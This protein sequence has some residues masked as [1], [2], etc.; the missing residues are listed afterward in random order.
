M[1]DALTA[2][3]LA[4]KARQNAMIVAKPFILANYANNYIPQ[5]QKISSYF[6]V[7]F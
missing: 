4:E 1:E 2:S 7:D 6:M 3:T 5:E